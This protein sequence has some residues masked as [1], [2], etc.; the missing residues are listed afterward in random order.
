MP[1]SPKFVNVA[2][3]LACGALLVVGSS[4]ARAASDS[5]SAKTAKSG[6]TAAARSHKTH[7]KVHKTRKAS[8]KRHGQKGI[9]SAR[10]REIQEAL[11]R[12]NYL[13]GQP[14]GLWDSRSKSA[15]TRYQADN[16]WQSK[17]VPDS[18]ALIKLGLGPDH[19]DLINPDTAAVLQPGGGAERPMPAQQTSQS[20]VGPS[21]KQ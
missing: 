10:V 17:V 9:E 16:G 2:L 13:S 11:I 12:E 5:S 19:A 14:T 7:K 8:W 18:R 20:R 3:A 21:S 4:T 6:K 15:M 1:S